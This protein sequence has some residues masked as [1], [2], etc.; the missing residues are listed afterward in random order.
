MIKYDNSGNMDALVLCGGFATR[1]EPLTTFMPKM[2]LPVNGK[3]LLDHILSVI[4]QEEVNRVIISTNKKFLDQFE[5]F[6]DRKVKSGYGKSIE[7]VVEP[8]LKNEEKIGAVGGIHYAI[9]KAEIDSDLL[10][11]A[12]DNYFNFKLDPLLKHFKK[13]RVPTVA[14]YDVKSREDASRFGVVSIS[15][16]KI[17]DFEEKP[18]DP[19]SSIVSTGIYV[20]PKEMLKEFK[21]YLAL[22]SRHDAPGYFLRFLVQ[23]GELHGVIYY[24]KWFDIGTLDTYKEVFNSYRSLG[25]LFEDGRLKF[26]MKSSSKK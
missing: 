11:I 9:E 10:V 13:Y 23:K 20:F 15:G 12:G 8:T 22:P 16:N 5:Y 24:D 25:I 21:S 3:P 7:I 2:L 26:E 1:L 4:E 19:K 14:L 6:L 18:N 17:T